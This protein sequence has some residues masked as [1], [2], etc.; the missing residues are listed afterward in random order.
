MHCRI[1][2]AKSSVL[3]MLHVCNWITFIFP[4]CTGSYVGLRTKVA[5]INNDNRVLTEL[6]MTCSYAQPMKFMTT[7]WST[8]CANM[9]S[10][11]A[12]SGLIEAKSILFS[13]L[14]CTR[15]HTEMKMHDTFCSEYLSN[16]LKLFWICHIHYY[17]ARYLQRLWEEHGW[18]KIKK[19]S[20]F[21]FSIRN[22]FWGIYSF[23]NSRRCSINYGS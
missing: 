12:R 19:W 17:S 2:H 22:N 13:G 16:R 7:R 14:D 3:Q 23:R 5:C 21:L 6:L 11:N 1:T 9:K 10:P 4:G 18:S 8:T 20:S 15:R